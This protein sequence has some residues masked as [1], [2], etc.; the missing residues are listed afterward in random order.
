[1]ADTDETQENDTNQGDEGSRLKEEKISIKFFKKWL[2]LGQSIYD[3]YVV[4]VKVFISTSIFIAFIFLAY[5][6]GTDIFSDKIV[7][8]PFTV[9]PSLEKQGYTG[10]VIV[11]RIMSKMEEIRRTVSS[12]NNPGVQ[13]APPDKG[14][15][16]EI[17][18]TGVSLSAIMSYLRVFL[19]VPPLKVSGSVVLGKETHMIIEI[20]GKNTGDFVGD[21]DEFDKVINEAAVY[22]LKTLEPLTLARHFYIKKK[23]K[24]LKDLSI[25]IEGNDPA[26]KEKAV[27]LLIDGLILFGQKGDYEGALK[28]WEWAEGLDPEDPAPLY[29]Q[30]WALDELKRYDEAEAKFKKALQLAPDFAGVY[31]SWGIMLFNKNQLPEAI[32]MFKKSISLNSNYAKGYNNWG[33][34]LMEMGGS[35]EAIEKFQQAIKIDP[36]NPEFHDSWGDSLVKLGKFEEGA[37]KFDQA[38]NLDAEFDGAFFRSGKALLNVKGR[39]E[40]GIS[41]IAQAIALNP[42]NITYRIALGDALIE[43]DRISEGIK[44][45]EEAVKKAPEEALSNLK[46]GK[47]L[48]QQGKK[49]EA[50]PF[51]KKAETLDKKGETGKEASRLIGEI[52]K[53]GS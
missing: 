43:Q 36:K 8:Q 12:E 1:M 47:S 51:L 10:N 40:E 23:W 9:P 45:F 32:G 6:A 39:E 52:E 20:P 44:A 4:M 5:Q 11:S 30:G 2:K 38:S 19:G 16:I 24:A 26:P 49:G 22:L 28:R 48:Y 31:N 46:L 14:S 35:A 7:V 50:L 27:A 21:T 25:Y 42:D 17:P 15:D 37:K 18:G 3:F 33:Y 41:K 29:H 34:I 13:M 53:T